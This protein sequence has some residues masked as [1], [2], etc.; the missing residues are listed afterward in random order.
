MSRLNLWPWLGRALIDWAIIAACL[1]FVAFYGNVASF[2]LASLVIGTRQHALAILGHDG[3][4]R[5]ITP[6]KRLNDFLTASCLYPLG[7]SLSGYRRFHFDH[8]R[9]VSTE[10]DPELFHKNLVPQWSLPLRPVRVGLH[11]LGDLV[12]FGIPHIVIGAALMRPKR[13]WDILP[14]MLFW[15]CVICLCV[16]LNCLWIPAL[17]LWSSLTA[18]WMVFRLRIWT[19]HVGAHDTH[20]LARPPW[21][22]RMIFLPH[23][24][25]CHSQHHETP[26]VPCWQLGKTAAAEGLT[27]SHLVASLSTAEPD[28]GVV[29]SPSA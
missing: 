21:W 12:G 2:V 13:A 1:V 25:W 14:V 19:E 20:A 28:T 3:A 9:H 11:L 17:W 6:H 26:Q 22:A 10:R 29:S 5:L 24:T 23:N 18:F 15:A 16:S 27:L 8:H 7:V 4:H